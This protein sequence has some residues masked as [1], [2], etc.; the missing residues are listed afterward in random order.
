VTFAVVT[1]S[2][3]LMERPALRL[4]GRFGRMPGPAPSPVAAG[5]S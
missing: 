1:A 2:Y 5:P 3:Y 4:K